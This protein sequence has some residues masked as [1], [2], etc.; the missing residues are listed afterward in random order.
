ME[1]VAMT[2]DVIVR[3]GRSRVTEYEDHFIV[4]LGPGDDLLRLVA[5]AMAHPGRAAVL[6]GPIQGVVAMGGGE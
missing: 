3:V 4:D 6:R 5:G 2:E 1:A